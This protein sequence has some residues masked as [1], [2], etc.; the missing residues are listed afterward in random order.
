[1]H[2]YFIFLLSYRFRNRVYE[3]VKMVDQPDEKLDDNEK[4]DHDEDELELHCN[5]NPLFSK[6]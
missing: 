4:R 5:Q 6:L 1:M 3:K 2:V